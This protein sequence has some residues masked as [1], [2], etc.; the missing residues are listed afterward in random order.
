MVAYGTRQQSRRA[1][2]KAVGFAKLKM[3]SAP[4]HTPNCP[5]LPASR[6]HKG[7]GQGR[8]LK[9]DVQQHLSLLP[10]VLSPVSPGPWLYAL[11][12]FL[13]ARIGHSQVIRGK[14]HKIINPF[15]IVQ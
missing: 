7:Q 8:L 9:A 11:P 6:D 13:F 4:R 5:P 12:N 1:V 3:P 14:S 15:T 2:T 10:V